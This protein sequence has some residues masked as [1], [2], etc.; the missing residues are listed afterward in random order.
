MLT[1]RR[2]A[3]FAAIVG[4]ILCWYNVFA[5]IHEFGHVF[6][7]W[8]IFKGAGIVNWTTAWT[9]TYA[10]FVTVS[11]A[12]G[13]ILA[14][15]LFTAV[16]V[17]HDSP[18]LWTAPGAAIAEYIFFFG[19]KDY[20]VIV[21]TFDPPRLW[22]IVFSLTSIVMIAAQV[23]MITA[24]HRNVTERTPSRKEIILRQYRALGKL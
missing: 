18:Y 15:L 19:S 3:F 2:K 22:L 13:M 9:T 6:A 14:T 17:K 24:I 5:I 16:F 7:S 11:G 10:M 12:G 8:L 23:A 4:Y 21:A 1:W 20:A